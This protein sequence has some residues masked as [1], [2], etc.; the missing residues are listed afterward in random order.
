MLLYNAS[1]FWFAYSHCPAWPYPQSVWWP[2]R[3]GHSVENL[4]GSVN[5]QNL[6]CVYIGSV[7]ATWGISKCCTLSLMPYIPYKSGFGFPVSWQWK[8]LPVILPIREL[9]ATLKSGFWQKGIFWGVLLLWNYNLCCFNSI[10]LYWNSGYLLKTNLDGMELAEHS[11]L[12]ILQRCL[13]IPLICAFTWHPF[14]ECLPLIKEFV[15]DSLVTIA[16][17]KRRRMFATFKKFIDTLV[18]YVVTT[19]NKG[20]T[21][22]WL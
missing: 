1:I 13:S 2:S 5:T 6:V 3:G 11:S 22:Q 15:L 4:L 20:H 17:K 19:L 18:T 14:M 9:A 21:S 7:M 10:Q 16:K 12:I 8:H